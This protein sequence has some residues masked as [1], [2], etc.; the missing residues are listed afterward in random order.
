LADP[1]Y[2]LDDERRAGPPR[3]YEDRNN[4]FR[5]IA[6]TLLAFCGG[7]ALLFLF[8]ALIGAVDVGE[9]TGLAIAAIAFA[10]IWLVGMWFRRRSGVNV[11][12]VTRA[13]RE[14]RGF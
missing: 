9:A 2:D 11:Q 7:L 10:L 3:R 1:Y 4:R 8:F 14:R 12:R 13:D 6:A 5:E